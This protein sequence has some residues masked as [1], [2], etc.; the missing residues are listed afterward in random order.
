MYLCNVSQRVISNF[1]AIFLDGFFE[2]G[3]TNVANRYLL[4]II[5]VSWLDLFPL[6]QKIIATNPGSEYFQF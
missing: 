3:N 2:T 4:E 5:V 1:I 6:K